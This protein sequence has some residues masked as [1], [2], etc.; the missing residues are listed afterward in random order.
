M[1]PSEFEFY[2][3]YFPIYEWLAD[4]LDNM[5]EALVNNDE[6]I[7]CIVIK[8]ISAGLAQVRNELNIPMP[9]IPNITS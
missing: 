9:L 2:K 4:K 5:K 8:E 6:E 1:E 3:D 7:F